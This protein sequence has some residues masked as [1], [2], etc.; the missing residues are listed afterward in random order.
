M[1]G[2]VT[3]YKLEENEEL[4]LRIDPGETVVITVCSSFGSGESW[5]YP[6]CRIQQWT[7]SP[8][9]TLRFL[10]ANYQIVFPFHSQ[11]YGIASISTPRRSPSIRGSEVCLRWRVML[12]IT[13]NPKKAW[14]R[15]TPVFIRWYAL[16]T[17]PRW[18][19]SCRQVDCWP[20][21]TILQVHAYLSLTILIP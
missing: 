19:P 11:A 1:S 6:L 18:T 16:P 17:S 8:F 12:L 9:L 3:T 5:I 21:R 2:I 15:P 20:T 7:T 13:T 14:W 10:E 4:Q